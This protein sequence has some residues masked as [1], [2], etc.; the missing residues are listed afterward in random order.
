MHCT[1]VVL[2]WLMEKLAPDEGEGRWVG[3]GCF[4]RSAP[5][6]GPCWGMTSAEKRKAKG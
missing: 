1:M 4:S 5:E 3:D 2:E 6:R